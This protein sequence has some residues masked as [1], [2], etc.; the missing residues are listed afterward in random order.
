MR[1]LTQT[2]TLVLLAMVAASC[3]KVPVVTDPKVLA[4]RWKCSPQE[5]NIIIP[6]KLSQATPGSPCLAQVM[7]TGPGNPKG[8]RRNF[9]TWQVTNACEDPFKVTIA[10]S[11]FDLNSSGNINPGQTKPITEIIRANARVT[12]PTGGGSCPTG[13][14][15]GPPYKYDIS[16]GQTLVLDPEL[17]IEP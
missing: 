14:V 7:P 2:L 15:C 5:P 11:P 12:T 17:E 1:R 13:L 9:V 16:V 3:A 6:V 8:C 4:D 10:F